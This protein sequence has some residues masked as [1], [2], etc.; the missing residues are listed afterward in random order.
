MH[1]F[2]LMVLVLSGSLG[3][4][5]PVMAGDFDGQRTL[6]CHVEHGHE[7][8][9]NGIAKAFDPESVGLPRAF[10]I[11]FQKKE[12]GPTGESRVR[13]HTLIMSLGHVEDKLMLQGLDEGL[14]GV[15]DGIGWSMSLSTANGAFVISAAGHRVGYVVFGSCVAK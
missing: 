2:L 15:T 7:W 8:H 4:L 13:K 9:D 3:W 12:I 1:R 14:D 11:D 6:L 10:V 5:H